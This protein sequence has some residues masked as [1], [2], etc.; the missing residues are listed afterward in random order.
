M[1][2]ALALELVWL[3]LRT[4]LPWMIHMIILERTL[5]AALIAGPAT[6]LAARLLPVRGSR[7]PPNPYGG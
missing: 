6:A 5:V 3:P 4:A 1:L 7:S 2:Y